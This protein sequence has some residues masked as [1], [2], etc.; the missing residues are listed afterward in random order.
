MHA[1][2]SYDFDSEETIPLQAVNAASV[3]NSSRRLGASNSEVQ[4]DTA[5][6]SEHPVKTESASHEVAQGETAAPRAVFHYARSGH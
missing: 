3:E 5:P 4:A 6:P 2:Q 1:V